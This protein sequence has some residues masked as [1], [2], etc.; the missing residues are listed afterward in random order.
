MR[1]L[2]PAP[3]DLHRLADHELLA[4]AVEGDARA[5]STIHQRHAPAAHAAARRILGPTPAVEDVVQDALLQLWRDGRRYAPERGSLRAWLVVLARSRALDLLRR[6]RSRAAASERVVARASYAD[7]AAEGADT[8]AGRRERS[9][10]IVSGL[11]GLPREQGQVLGLL[12]LGERTQ[13]EIAST[14]DLPLGT[15]KGRARLGMTKLR[16]HLDPEL[17]A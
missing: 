3:L 10:T 2:A 5:F 11:A 17:A 16:R 15:V 7:A 4:L 13:M 1:Q 14:L 9:R 8:A 6:D 12:Y